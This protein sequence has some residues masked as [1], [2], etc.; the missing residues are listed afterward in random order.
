[1]LRSL[2]TKVDACMRAVA[3]GFVGRTAAAAKPRAF[4]AKH[5]AAG[6]RTD[7]QIAENLE[8]PVCNGCDAQSSTA[9]L[10]RIGVNRRRLARRNE[11]GLAMA[12]V[13]ERFVFR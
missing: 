8:R 3:E 6:A 12:I 11:R 10:K 4:G 5:G 13:A 1:M 9:L 2:Q 7:F